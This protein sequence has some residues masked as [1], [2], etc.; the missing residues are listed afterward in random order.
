MRGP[1]CSHSVQEDATLSVNNF[2][3][4][5]FTIE[6]ALNHSTFNRISLSPFKE[7]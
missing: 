7:I 5:Y 2:L 3:N 4:T 6:H 1:C